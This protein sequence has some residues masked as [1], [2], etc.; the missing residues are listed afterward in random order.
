M[1][2]SRLPGKVL[3]QVC[4]RTLLELQYERIKAAST[5]DRVIIATTDGAPDEAI[6][7]LCDRENIEC[8]RGSE[9]DVL[10][11]YYQAAR[12][13]GSSPDD[14]IIRVTGDCP[15]LDPEVLDQVVNFFWENGVDY[16]SNINPP[17]F[18][19]GLDVEIFKYEALERAW[20]EASLTSEREHVTPYL[21]N[22][23]EIFSQAN[24]S[25]AIDLSQLRLT[26]DEPED[27]EIIRFIYDSLYHK[28]RIFLM[29]DILELIDEN[30]NLLDINRGAM[31]NEGYEKSLR[32]DKRPE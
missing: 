27:L 9:N 16:A 18:P 28:K 13:A 21:R 2:S 30:P 17:T 8:Y 14:A 6:V 12:Q 22:H 26:V 31:R 25:N 5:V 24:Y 29:D 10:D 4:G 19:D 11:R 7:E 1:G 15:L 23:P 20:R 32:E 3:K